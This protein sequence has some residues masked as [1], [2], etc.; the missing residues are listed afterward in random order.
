MLKKLIQVYTH[1]GFQCTLC[2]NRDQAWPLSL[3]RCDHPLP[4]RG[5]L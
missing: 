4:T 3:W 2:A 5:G 1:C